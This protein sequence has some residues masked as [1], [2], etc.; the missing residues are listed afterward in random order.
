MCPSACLTHCG[1]YHEM[2]IEEETGSMVSNSA[3]T[4][5]KPF[6]IKRC[7]EDERDDYECE[8]QCVCREGFI[9]DLLSGNCVTKEI[10]DVTLA[11]FDETG[12][13]YPCPSHEHWSECI[14]E[15]CVKYCHENYEPKLEENVDDGNETMIE[16]IQ[17]RKIDEEE[18]K[19]PSKCVQGCVCDEGY[20]RLNKGA[21]CIPD[22]EC[23]VMLKYLTS[24]SNS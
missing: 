1:N 8:A 11:D 9:R 23:N 4:T 2:I 10:C 5:I 13:R 15:Q 24:S 12:S 19:K 17:I 18:C 16:P 20:M 21:K 14:N 6:R 22:K 7:L 3:T